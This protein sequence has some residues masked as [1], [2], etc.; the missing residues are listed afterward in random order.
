MYS[1]G[2]LAQKDYDEFQA[3]EQRAFLFFDSVINTQIEVYKEKG[4][5][6]PLSITSPKS[7][8]IVFI[9]TLLKE[10]KPNREVDEK[11]IQ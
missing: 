10:N 4:E 7:E 9:K 1:I 2:Q 6:F 5:E 11:V 8:K 3:F